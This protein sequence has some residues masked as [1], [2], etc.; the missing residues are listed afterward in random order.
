MTRL[1]KVY[2]IESKKLSEEMGGLSIEEI[3]NEFCPHEFFYV[4]GCSVSRTYNI[5]KPERLPQECVDCWN[6]EY[7]GEDIF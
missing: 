5:I 7:K 6:T 1:E 3:K 4:D 2:E